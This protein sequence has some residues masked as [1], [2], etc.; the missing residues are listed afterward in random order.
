MILA[1]PG[2][3]TLVALQT[4]QITDLVSRG[5][6]V[7]AMDHPH[8]SYAAEQPDGTLIHSVMAETPAFRARLLDVAAVLD[9]LGG[10][11]AAQRCCRTAA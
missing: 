10:A 9:H 1:S 3:G 7:I 4:G 8:D 2:Y 6:A 5:Y 11:A